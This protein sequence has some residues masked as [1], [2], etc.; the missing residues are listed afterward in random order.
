MS[1]APTCH[2]CSFLLCRY[3]VFATVLTDSSFDAPDKQLLEEI[4][5]TEYEIIIK[6]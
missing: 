6:L 5:T 1:I 2:L 4:V 3:L